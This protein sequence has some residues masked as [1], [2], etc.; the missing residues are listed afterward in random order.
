MKK[1]STFTTEE[2]RFLSNF[3]PHKKNGEKFEHLVHVVYNQIVFDC[4]ENAYQAAK[5]LDVSLQKK[6]AEMSPYETKAYWDERKAEVRSDWE[7]A[8][9]QI[10][11]DLVEQKFANS[12]SLAKLLLETGELLLEEGNDWGDVYWGIDV[13]SGIGENYLGKILMEIRAKLR[14]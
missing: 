1:I 8:K 2:H 9:F 3:Y 6:M 7:V 14:K 13:D 12:Q 10:M 5:S 11:R 4:V